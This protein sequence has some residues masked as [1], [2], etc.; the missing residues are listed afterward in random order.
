M[1]ALIAG[2][3]A[4]AAI[5]GALVASILQHRAATATAARNEHFTQTERLRAERGDLFHEHT[6]TDDSP[7]DTIETARRDRWA[8]RRDMASA[9]D[10][11]R[12][13][14]QDTGLLRLADHLWADTRALRDATNQQALDQRGDTARAT[15]DAFTAAAATYLGNA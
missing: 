14:I 1:D 2:I 8:S 10:D 7:N 9:R 4:L 3:A 15:H 5:L 6:L 11:L 13:L 12:L